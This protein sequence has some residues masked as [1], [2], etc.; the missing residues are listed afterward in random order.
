MFQNVLIIISVALRYRRIGG[1]CIGLF[2]ELRP[3]LITQNMSHS[4]QTY[5]V[6]GFMQGLSLEVF[7]MVRLSIK[8]DA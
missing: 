5:T 2:C 7:E 1:A 4:Q 3:I 6:D 8:Q